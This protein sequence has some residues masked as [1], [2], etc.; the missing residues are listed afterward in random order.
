MPSEK[1]L[2]SQ[3]NS[4]KSISPRSDWKNSNRSVLVAQI[5]GPEAGNNDQHEGFKI[6]VFDLRYILGVHNISRPVM[7]SA[8]VVFLLF[9]TV[10]YGGFVALSS[11]PGDSLYAVKTAKEKTQYAL[12]FSEKQRAELALQFAA[13][14]AEELSAVM[15]DVGKNPE[16]QTKAEELNEKIKIELNNATKQISRMDINRGAGVM[17]EKPVQPEAKLA[18]TSQQDP[19]INDVGSVSIAGEDKDDSGITVSDPAAPV[20]KSADMTPEETQEIIKQ[21]KDLV[22]QEK[23]S[24]AIEKIGEMNVSEEKAS[25]TD[26]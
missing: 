17:K 15:Q 23:Y 14:R 26:R 13:N 12:T 7:A 21:V 20:V 24:E 18:T 5:I 16:A 2:I 22:L 25:S 11:M 9:L 4:F 10:I 19:E 3:L 6:S 1:D 8:M